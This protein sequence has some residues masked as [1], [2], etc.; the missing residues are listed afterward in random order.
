MS[1]GSFVKMQLILTAAKVPFQIRVDT[2][3]K[4]SPFRIMSSSLHVM[5]LHFTDLQFFQGKQH[6]EA[7]ACIKNTL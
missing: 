2:F 5:V 1:I 6:G 4:Y 3:T 7:R